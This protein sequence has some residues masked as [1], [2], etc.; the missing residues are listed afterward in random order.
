MLSQGSF[1]LIQLS[2][3]ND[4]YSMIITYNTYISNSCLTTID[5]VL[6]VCKQLNI[7]FEYSCFCHLN[8]LHFDS[9]R[10]LMICEK[11]LWFAS[12]TAIRPKYNCEDRSRYWSRQVTQEELNSYSSNSWTE[13]MAASWT[14]INCLRLKQK[15]ES[16]ENGCLRNEFSV[17]SNA[18]KSRN[19]REKSNWKQPTAN[20]LIK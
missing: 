5:I 2:C 17:T 18:R 9:T 13:S 19:K 3:L 16:Q 6:S 15:R 11:K 14:R 12:T 7:F 20:R 8:M 4:S 10:Y 1:R